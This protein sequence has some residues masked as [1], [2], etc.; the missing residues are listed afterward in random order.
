MKYQQFGESVARFRQK[1]GISA[2]EL[3][4]RINKDTTYISKVEKGIVNVRLSVIYEIC[5][6]LDIR[7]TDL[8][9]DSTLRSE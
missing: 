8:F 1:K 5:V 7:P 3:S 9:R 6:A 4:L 2:Y